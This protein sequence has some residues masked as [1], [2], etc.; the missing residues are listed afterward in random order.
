MTAAIYNKDDKARIPAAIWTAGLGVSVAAHI[1][2]LIFGVPVL[3]WK[4]EPQVPPAETK[5]IIES[6]DLIFEPAEQVASVVADTAAP[7]ASPVQPVPEVTPTVAP[8]VVESQS[9]TSEAIQP[10]IAETENISSVV[11]DQQP[12]NQ[13]ET[14][15]LAVV[16]QAT[17]A[18]PQQVSQAE[19][20]AIASVPVETVIEPVP[21]KIETTGSDA[22]VA[23]PPQATVIVTEVTSPIVVE[24]NPE[25]VPQAATTPQVTQVPQISSSNGVVSAQAVESVSQTR[26]QSSVA[27][28][29]VAPAAANTTVVASQTISPSPNA[30]AVS[31]VSQTTP[32]VSSVET[33]AP[34]VSSSSTA[35]PVAVSNNTPASQVGTV[36]AVEPVASA[37]QVEAGTVQP[38]EP[39]EEV[40]ASLAPSEI[41]PPALG[42]SDPETSSVPAAPTSSDPAPSVQP[43]EVA[44]IDPLANVTAY[45]ASYDAGECV[46]LSVM[47]AGT[48]TAQVTAFGAAIDPFFKFDQRFAADQGYEAD[49]EVRLVTR[50]QCQVLDAL[51]VSKGVEAPGLVEL[52][53]TVVTSGARVSG[54]IQRDL[55]LGRIAQAEQSGLRLNGKGPPELYLIDDAGQIHDGRA[56]VRVQNSTTRVGGWSFSI[57]VTL[58]TGGQTETALLLAV[59]N[60]PKESQPPRFGTLSAERI[61]GVLAEP[62]VFSLSAFK[63]SR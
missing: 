36:A 53:R 10:Q 41:N 56:F 47:S 38:V 57:P 4:V 22:V 49:I 40:I 19:A 28:V 30:V 29:Q 52:D 9:D 20:V 32:V 26:P 54:V 45:V 23:T 55:P 34:V 43:D 58:V 14:I 2:I 61:A 60:R 42:P 24:A 50:R 7:N 16:E 37:V 31:S 27:T 1:G 11:P 13:A 48:D 17:S 39:V 33:V 35:A 8:S 25:S 63:V 46:H 12:A 44:T 3:T 5:I 51:D 18:A 15:D 59:W 6:Q 21:E 62:G